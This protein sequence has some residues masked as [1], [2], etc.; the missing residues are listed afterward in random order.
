[1]YPK[2][3]DYLFSFNLNVDLLTLALENLYFN[4]LDLEKLQGKC[5]GCIKSWGDTSPIYVHPP[6]LQGATAEG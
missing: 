3:R 1:M 6:T 4:T 2:R 5:L